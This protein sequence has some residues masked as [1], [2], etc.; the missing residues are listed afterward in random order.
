MVSLCFPNKS[1][2][3]N[4]ARGLS[5]CWPLCLSPPH[6][7]LHSVLQPCPVSMMFRKSLS[8][9][10][11][12]TLQD[13]LPP[14]LWGRTVG[15]VSGL[16]TQCLAKEVLAQRK[17]LWRGSGFLGKGGMLLMDLCWST[18]PSSPPTCFLE[19]CVVF[20][21]SMGLVSTKTALRKLSVESCCCEWLCPD[22]VI[23]GLSL[24]RGQWLSFPFS[25]HFPGPCNHLGLSLPLPFRCPGSSREVSTAGSLP[26]TCRVLLHAHKLRTFCPLSLEG[27]ACCSPFAYKRASPSFPWPLPHSCTALP[28]LPPSPRVSLD[29]FCSSNWSVSA[30][31]HSLSPLPIFKLTLT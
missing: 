12:L 26:R 28:A 5:V 18:L 19:S 1:R 22:K 6:S 17:Y 8:S 15:L 21:G 25:S 13:P 30:R 2:F 31:S 4:L 3:L 24:A 27:P 16:P 7:Q 14:P 9:F 10:N 20:S 23:L 29:P 11:L